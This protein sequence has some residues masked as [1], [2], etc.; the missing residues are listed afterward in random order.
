M[1]DPEEVIAQKVAEM[2][3]E[4]RTVKEIAEELGLSMSTIYRLL[5]KKGVQ[6]RRKPYKARGR[7][8]PEEL[9]QIKQLYQQGESIYSIAKKLNRPASTIYYA[10]KRMGYIGKT[11]EEQQ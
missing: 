4:G 1:V 2:Y 11:S 10:L 7:L 8:T 5:A 9:E 3:K 6:L